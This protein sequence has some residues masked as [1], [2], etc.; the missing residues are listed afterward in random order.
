MRLFLLP[1]LFFTFLCATFS[2]QKK[3]GTSLEPEKQTVRIN[4]IYSPFALDPRK[5]TDPVTTVL[6]F[7]LYEG[8]TRLEPDGRVSMALAERVKILE[9]RTTYLFYL[10]EAY[11][12]DGTPITAYDFEDSWKALLDPNFPSK[13]AHLLYP[14]KNGERARKGEC[15][16]DEVG[17]KALSETK[18]LVELEKPIPYFLELTA[19]C[20]F[21]PVPNGGKEVP[22]PNGRQDFVFSGPFRLKSWVND[23]EVVAEK[24]PFYWNG[25]KVQIE[26][27][28]ATIISEEATAL[29]LYEQG[30][31]DWIGGLISPLPLDAVSVMKKSLEIRQ[32]PIAGTTLTTFNL[33]AY[34]FNNVNI[35]KAF[36]Y[37]VNR[38][39]LVENVSQMFDDV[40]TGPVPHVL[41]GQNLAPLFPDNSPE[42]AQKHFER[43]LQELGMTREEFPKVTYSYFSSELQR[44]LALAL[45]SQWKEVLGVEVELQASELKT[46]LAHLYTRNYQ[47][48]QMSWI[49]QYHDRMN[50]LER[51]YTKDTFRNYSGWENA[52]FSTLIA[53][54]F[55]QEFEKRLSLLDQAEKILIDEMPIIPLY[56]YHLVYLKNPRLKNVA[57]SPMGDIQFHKAYLHKL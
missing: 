48:G 16:F 3:E 2:C 50:F 18:L 30:K 45:Q 12:S 41:K 47:L 37:A 14:L 17:V 20:T 54:S 40:A 15:S 42:L 34:P 11:W 33:E 5:C 19:F 27:I 9:D 51:F 53:E 49:G 39:T 52:R 28:R 8:L 10:R 46:H 36:A 55:Y 38:E 31:L 57:I 26:E 22:H 25:D 23:D 29:K 21:F 24:N 7:M 44:N 4:F 43:G 32:R 13:T 35:R 1:I 56:H 6:S